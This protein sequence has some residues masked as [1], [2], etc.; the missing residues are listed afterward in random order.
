[1]HFD[2]PIRV[3]LALLPLLNTSIAHS[4]PT[5]PVLYKEKP[6]VSLSNFKPFVIEA[7]AYFSSQ[8]KEQNINIFYLAGNRYTVKNHNESNG[9]FGLGYYFEGFNTSRFQMDFGIKALYLA[10]TTVKGT[11]IQELAY[12][13]L[14]YRY[15]IEH[16][17][18]YYAAKVL[19][20]HNSPQYNVTFDA[21][22]GP[23]IMRSS[24]Y[25]ETPLTNYTIPDNGFSSHNTITA[26]AMAGVGLRVNNLLGNTSME[27]GY[28]FLYLGQGKLSI[29]NDQVINPIKTGTSYAN[30]VLCSL[31]L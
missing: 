3:L 29:T 11:I 30:A 4:Q 7:G 14:S 26:T 8:G 6:T 5:K 20:K 25:S 17:P 31:I 23:N 15:S 22:V 27:C 16:V 12:T 2:K 18:I 19:L 9:L 10:P 21:G 24:G 1:M 13:N 28:R